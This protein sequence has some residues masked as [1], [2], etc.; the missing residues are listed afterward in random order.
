MSHLYPSL[1]LTIV[2]CE[3][4]VAIWIVSAL[5]IPHILAL[6]SMGG[7]LVPLSVMLLV[8]LGLWLLVF[9]LDDWYSWQGLCCMDWTGCVSV[10]TS[11]GQLFLVVR[12]QVLSFFLCVSSL[13]PWTSGDGR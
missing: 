6:S 12:S 1:V 7:R 2:D 9:N 10:C 4:A 3:D 13:R 11:M 8:V 5:T